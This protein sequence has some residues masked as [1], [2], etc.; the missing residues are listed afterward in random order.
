MHL[1]L[2]HG[3]GACACALDLLTII[4]P[5]L[6]IVPHAQSIIIA[7]ARDIHMIVVY[8]GAQIKPA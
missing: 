7:C 6:K 4:I 5:A 8:Y 1:A 2:G 3:Y